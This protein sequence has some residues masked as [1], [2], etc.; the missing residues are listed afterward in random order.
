MSKLLVLAV[1]S[2]IIGSFFLL[3]TGNDVASLLSLL[4]ALIP[5]AF[6]GLGIGF[7]IPRTGRVSPVTEDLKKRLRAGMAYRLCALTRDGND[8][9]LLVNEVGT[10]K[11]HAI[12]I[13]G[14]EPPP[15]YFTVVD[16]KPVAIPPPGPLVGGHLDVFA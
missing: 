11:F 6:S 1:F 10:G 5:A 15:E 9:I 12:R 2:L 3:A 13:A 16:N 4:L 8:L 7:L 14:P